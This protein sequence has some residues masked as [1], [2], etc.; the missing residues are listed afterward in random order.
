M[1]VKNSTVIKW[2]Q[3][4]EK[5]LLHLHQ[6]LKP[7]DL[8]SE[9]LQ[10]LSVRLGRTYG[11]VSR[12]YYHLF[13][14]NFFQKND[15]VKKIKEDNKKRKYVVFWTKDKLNCLKDELQKRISK[16]KKYKD[17]ITS[18][19]GKF[20]LSRASIESKIL[21]LKKENKVNTWEE[22]YEKLDKNEIVSQIKTRIYQ[23]KNN[24]NTKKQ[25][26]KTDIP[27]FLDKEK[28]K[29]K[30]EEEIN[31]SQNNQI[32]IHEETN[33]SV[34]E[35]QEL[36]FTEKKSTPNKKKTLFQMIKQAYLSYKLIVLQNKINKI[37][38]SMES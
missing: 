9:K 4:E 14:N 26:T 6:S 23:K 24:Q 13:K 5:M 36:K 18:L 11:A 17:M 16:Q 29:N 27:L 3:E 33:T 30:N 37:K 21:E 12:H 35:N 22:L 1:S 2:T 8:K 20:F 31:V 32:E 34:E 10:E 15:V 25:K 38:K 28:L 7:N 19:E